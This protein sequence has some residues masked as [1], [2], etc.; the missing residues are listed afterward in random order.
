MSI[1]A[2]VKSV[3]INE[4]GTGQLNLEGEERGQPVLFFE[5]APEDVTAL[6]GR[7]IWGSADSLMAGATKIANR[8]GYTGIEF[9]VGNFQGVF[10]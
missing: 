1:N 10:Q 5:T 7:K 3:Y 6:N 9:V 4:D 8:N 2:T